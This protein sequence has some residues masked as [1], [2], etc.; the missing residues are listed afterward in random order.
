[1]ASPL[2]PVNL[3][4]V[5]FATHAIAA[6][7]PNEMKNVRGG[8]NTAELTGFSGNYPNAKCRPEPA[9]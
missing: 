1:M 2:H 5:W 6:A 4:G 7:M 3:I 8:R 9:N